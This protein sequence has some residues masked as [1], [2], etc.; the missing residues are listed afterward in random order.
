M[1]SDAK[2]ADGAAVNLSIFCFWGE[3]QDGKKAAL[4]MAWCHVTVW[5]LWR[6]EGMYLF[7]FRFKV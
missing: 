3:L 2:G 5:T 4:L 1:V 7:E 6:V